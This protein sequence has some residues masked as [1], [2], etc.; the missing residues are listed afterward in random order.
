MALI[1]FAYR[2]ADVTDTVSR[3]IAR[4]VGSLTAATAGA[5]AVGLPVSNVPRPITCRRSRFAPICLE[6]AF[7]LVLT[8]A[9]S[10]S[11]IAADSLRSFSAATAAAAAS[12][13][14]CTY[15]PVAPISASLSLL[16]VRDASEAPSNLNST[17]PTA[18]I[19]TITITT[20]NSRSRPR[21]VGWRRGMSE[22]AVERQS[23]RRQVPGVPG[24]E[25]YN[26]ALDGRFPIPAGCSGL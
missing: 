9:A 12:R 26:A 24:G 14:A 8:F 10:L 16:S 3:P 23:N 1:R 18:T 22:R 13:R 20:K 17:A 7:R 25:S 6:S 15:S 5:T 11:R 19:G 21:K 2:W 4:P